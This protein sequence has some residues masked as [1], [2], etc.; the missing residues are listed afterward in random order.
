MGRCMRYNYLSLCV[1]ILILASMLFQT[2]E[3]DENP[4]DSVEDLRNEVSNVPGW[5]PGAL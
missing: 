4:A 2:E 1:G 5:P 3:T